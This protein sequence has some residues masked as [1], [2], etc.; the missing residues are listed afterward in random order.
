M[1]QS[2]VNL[3]QQAVVL[4]YKLPYNAGGVTI[5]RTVISTGKDA[6]RERGTGTCPS[7][8]NQRVV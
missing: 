4:Q 8:E 3:I 1:R 5:P 7:L 2:L 6:C